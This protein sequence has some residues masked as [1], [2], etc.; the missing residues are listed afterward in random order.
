MK[1]WVRDNTRPCPQCK[2]AIQKNNGCNHMTCRRESGGCGYEF[3]WVC[4]ADWRKTHG[5]HTGGYYQCNVYNKA[6]TNARLNA[7]RKEQHGTLAGS[8]SRYT[9]FLE[10]FHSH[11]ANAGFALKL[12]G[13]VEARLQRLERKGVMAAGELQYL[14]ATADTVHKAHQLLAWSYCFRYFMPDVRAA[15][16]SSRANNSSFHGCITLWSY[17]LD[18]RRCLQ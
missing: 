12:R 7:L 17:R 4:M 11:M 16:L 13:A 1:K 15:H 6:E 10:R 18:S 5:E 14:L 8:S 2:S 9:F 3:C